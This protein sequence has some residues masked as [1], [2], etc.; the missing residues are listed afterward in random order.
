MI[1]A[2][3]DLGAVSFSGNGNGGSNT[4]LNYGQIQGEIR[5]KQTDGSILFKPLKSNVIT[6]AFQIDG[7][8]VRIP[9]GLRDSSLQLG[10]AGQVLSSTGTAVS[11]IN[12]IPA[13]T[14]QMYAGTTLPTGRWLFC[15]GV[16]YT[17]GSPYNSLFAVIGYNFG[18][19][20]ANFNVPDFDGNLMVGTTTATPSTAQ[21]TGSVDAYTAANWTDAH[22]HTADPPVT[23]SGSP[24]ATTTVA[25]GTGAN[26]ASSTHTHATNVASFNTGS[27]TIDLSALKRSRVRYI[28]KY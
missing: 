26:V 6:T 13:G 10:T 27:T 8:A 15:D 7:D 24:S 1:S 20:G 23:T 11:W 25:S 28:I 12:L 22:T 5:N 9:F 17:T 14:I 19:L 16:S 3:D 2:G 4:R 21:Q 18:G